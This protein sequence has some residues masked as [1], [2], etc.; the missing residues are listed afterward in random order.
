VRAH[1]KQDRRGHE[2][3]CHLPPTALRERDE[4]R[5]APFGSGRLE[6]QPGQLAHELDRIP[7]HAGPHVEADDL[8]GQKGAD[9]RG[10]PQLA[11]VDRPDLGRAQ[12]A[13]PVIV[14]RRAAADE[15][16]GADRRSGLDGAAQLHLGEDVLIA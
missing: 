5:E 9:Q 11:E 4:R 12:L 14:M 8:E 1:H 13:R 2:E 15:A 16:A 10:E 7:V 3:A 6:R